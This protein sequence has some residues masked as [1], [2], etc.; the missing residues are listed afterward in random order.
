MQ[1][2]ASL[3]ERLHPCVFRDHVV[4]FMAIELS[5]CRSISINA[6]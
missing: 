3:G 6:M 5:E 1:Q 2:L 4:R